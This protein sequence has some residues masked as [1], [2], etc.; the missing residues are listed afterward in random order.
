MERR[1]FLGTCLA[2]GF[3]QPFAVLA[4]SDVQFEII[5][6]HT[7][8]YDPARPEG[9]PW[10]PRQSPLYRTV[11]PRHLRELKMYRPVTG[12]VVVE[13]SPWIEDNQ[14]LLDLAQ[15]DPFIVG[16]VG[17]L[18]PT[19]AEFPRNLLRFAAS[20]LYRGIRISAGVLQELLAKED[21]GRL[22]F[23]AEKNL[24]LDVNGGPETPAVL[25]RLA[26]K[27]PDLKIVLNHIGNVAITAAPPPGTWV[28]GIQAAAKHKNV[29]TKISAL[30]E[31]ASRDGRPAPADLEFYRPYLDVVWHAFG[32]QRVIYGSNWPVSDRGADYYTVQKLALDYAGEYGKQALKRFCSENARQVYGWVER[33]GRGD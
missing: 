1:T 19:D 20:P 29:C 3:V 9:V 32:D 27:L 16:I 21:W 15:K 6:C 11:L 10:P 22:K 12:T 24:T 7:H 23:L 8:F 18:L 31:G 14:W 17:N 33:P 30:V 5:D 13:A 25:A 2:A 4:E 28:E 26:E